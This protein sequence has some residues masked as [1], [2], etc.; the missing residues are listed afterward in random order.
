MARKTRTT[1][2]GRGGARALLV[3]AVAGAVIVRLGSA[4]LQVAWSSLAGELA[5]DPAAACARL[6]G[7]PLLDLPPV[8]ALG[9]RLRTGALAKAPRECASTVFLRLGNLQRK[10]IPLVADGDLNAAR[11]ALADGDVETAV[12]RLDRALD[13]DPTSPYLHRLVALLELSRG[14][15]EQALDELALAEGLAPGYAVP[16]VEV[17]PGDALWV[18][19]EGL[20]KRAELYPRRRDEALL[21]LGSKLWRLGRREEA[22]RTLEEVGSRPEADLLRAEWALEEGRPEEAAELARGVARRGMFPDRIRAR[23][24][25]TLARAL[26]AAGD[27]GAALRAASEA[28]RLDPGSPGPYVAMAR[29]ARRRGDL[30]SALASMRRA[31][32]VAPTDIGVLLEMAATAEAAGRGADAR[33]VLERATELAPDRPDVAARLVELLL[34][35][36][37]LMEAAMV[38]SRELERHPTDARLL[39]LAGR[40][41]DQSSR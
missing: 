4:S 9:L 18:E 16:R 14:R 13:R 30:E 31:W 6:A 38:L 27:S 17:L 10:W 23:A 20:R 35:Q 2:T 33:L 21:A 32:G 34:R 11:A 12:E 5:R 7:T 1:G 3:A 36:G 8:A 39:A 29:L 37:R 24:F 22:R 26:D 15:Y 40:L 41:G 25:S 19:L 28:V